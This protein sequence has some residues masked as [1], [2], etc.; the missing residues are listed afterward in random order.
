MER[1]ENANPKVDFIFSI[2]YLVFVYLSQGK[3]SLQY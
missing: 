1:L 3:L 2:E